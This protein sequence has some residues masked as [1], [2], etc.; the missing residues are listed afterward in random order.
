MS[1]S[2][3]LPNLCGVR[4]LTEYG[5]AWYWYG[6]GIH[7]AERSDPDPDGDTLEFGSTVSTCTLGR[8]LKSHLTPSTWCGRSTCAQ[9]I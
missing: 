9:A 4:S 8:Y 3:L 6:M 5:T 1:Y 7:S 2:G